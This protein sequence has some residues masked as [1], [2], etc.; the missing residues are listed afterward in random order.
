MNL[1]G[2]RQ[3]RL[4]YIVNVFERSEMNDTAFPELSTDVVAAMT[5]FSKA[6]PSERGLLDLSIELSTKDLTAGNEFS[7]FV[8]VKNPF[9]EPVWIDR[10]HVSLP[11]ELEQAISERARV[12][13][14]DVEERRQAEQRATLDASTELRNE[15]ASLGDQLKDMNKIA[16]GEN[17]SE[18]Q[19]TAERLLVKLEKEYR[20]DATSA[21][22]VFEEELVADKITVGANSSNIYVGGKSK[23]GKVEVFDP[24]LIHAQKGASQ[25]VEL[26][27]SLPENAALQPGSTAVFTMT[28]NVKHSVV[29]TPT[30]YRLQFNVVYRFEK[31]NQ[32]LDVSLKKPELPVF[33]NTIASD[34]S[35]RPS[36][37]SIIL[38]SMIGGLFG[39]IGRVLQLTDF[40]QPQVAT[41]L[42]VIGTGGALVLSVLLSA[43]AVIFI[44]RKSDSQSFVSVEDFWGGLLT[45]FL[46]G[47][48][49]TSFFT[50]LTGF[51]T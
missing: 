38:G 21:K 49:G 51:Q 6:R 31:E 23:I 22:I 44:A 12:K 47:Y 13:L 24:S 16:S 2:L 41:A 30:K 8:L 39:S 45:G 25:D 3:H 42:D 15:I 11:S 37:F 43:I 5:S 14:L 46:V 35:I 17:Q 32:Q 26:E 20:Q 4:W 18:V 9:N 28:L 40:S 1:V 50:D 7:V 29:F 34:L 10:V 36:V 48:S 33:A 19:R 27:G